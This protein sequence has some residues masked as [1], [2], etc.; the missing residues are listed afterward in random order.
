MPTSPAEQW[1]PVLLQM[2]LAMIIAAALVTLSFAIG[3]RVKNRVKDMPYECGIA[4]TG[5]ARERFSVKFYLVAMLFILFDIEAIF[6]YPWAV[7][8]KQLKMFAFL[9]MLVFVVLI[10]AGFFFIWKKGV[11]D[12]AEGERVTPPV[13]LKGM[14]VEIPAGTARKAAGR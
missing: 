14:L 11:L 13:N 4:P 1:L 10:L 5:D 6:L 8:Y 9:E 12:W 7:V 3:R 2:A